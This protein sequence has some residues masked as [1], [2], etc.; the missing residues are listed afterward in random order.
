MTKN[1]IIKSRKKSKI[2]IKIGDKFERLEVIKAIGVLNRNTCFECRCDC[3]N[4]RVVMGIHLYNGHTRSCGCLHQTHGMS[5]T[6]EYN[7]WIDMIQRCTN[8]KK[9]DYENYGGRGIAVC[10]RWL[11]FENFY[12]DMGERPKELTL[13]RIDNNKGYF[14]DNCKWGTK[15]EQARNQRVSRRSKTGVRGV[16]WNKQVEKYVVMIMV[17]YKHYF[18]G[19]FKSIEDAKLARQEAEQKYWS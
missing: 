16:C 4:I 10:R 8:L 17:K 3:G 14:P 2:K 12:E 9:A 11:K 1:N 5:N 18:I 6:P 19:Y 13:E 7:V 15:T